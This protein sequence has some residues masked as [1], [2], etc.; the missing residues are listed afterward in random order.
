GSRIRVVVAEGLIARDLDDSEQQSTGDNVTG[1]PYWWVAY[2]ALQ[3]ETGTRPP[4]PL[5]TDLRR[6]A[7]RPVLIIASATNPP[8]AHVAPVYARAAGPTASLWLAAAGHTRALATY[9]RAYARRVV[10]LFERSLV[11]ACVA[12]GSEVRPAARKDTSLPHVTAG[13]ERRGCDRPRTKGRRSPMPPLGKSKHVAARM[14]R[15]SASHWK[16][17]TFGWIAFVVAAFVVGMQLGTKHID[18]NKAGSGQSGHVQAVLADEFKQSQVE[19]VLIQSS[20]AT[21]STPAFQRTIEDVVSTLARQKA[22][23]AIDSPLVAGNEGQV[24]R[25]RR[26]A[27]VSFKLRGTELAKADKEVVPVERAVAALQKSHP[28]FFIGESGGAS[29][30]RALNARVTHDFEKTGRLSIPLTL[31]IRLVAFGA[32]IAAGL[33]I[34]LSL[35]AVAATMGLL[36]I[37][38][39][40]MPVD[41]DISVIVLLIGL[42]VGVD[43]SMFYLRREREERRAGKSERAALEAAAATSGR[44]VLVSGVTVMIAMAG[45][46]FTGDKTFQSFGLATMMVVAVAV[47]GSLTVLPALLAKLGDRVDKPRIPF[48]S[49]RRRADGESRMWNA[50]LNPVLRHPLVATLVAGGALVALA[51]PALQLPTPHPAPGPMPN[52]HPVP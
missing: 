30:D 27:L 9:P 14:G 52:S 31:A 4:E 11:R 42:A 43:Y 18:A 22:V 26:S 34:L 46:F 38:S 3:L 36:A 5:T 47:L 35:T 8:E 50:I 32:L 7:P 40:L 29:A 24:S 6:I 41:K 13:R 25:D 44:A 28:Q 19:D 48:V 10:G 33:P 12:A 1:V 49:R 17:A 23:Y 37:P 16:T 51:I 21:V 45:M 39:H 2:H 15:W 20:S